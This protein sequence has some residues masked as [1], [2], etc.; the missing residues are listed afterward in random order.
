MQ[1]LQKTGGRGSPDLVG[2]IESNRNQTHSSGVS[3]LRKEDLNYAQ[4]HATVFHCTGGCHNRGSS[5]WYGTDGLGTGNQKSRRHCGARTVLR[6]I[7][8]VLSVLRYLPVS[9]NLLGSKQRGRQAPHS[10]EG[11]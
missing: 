11:R 2:T 7:L 9:A 4:N 8:S 6:P 1:H 5:P 3:S 10:L